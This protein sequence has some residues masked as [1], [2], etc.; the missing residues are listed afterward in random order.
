MNQH[1]RLP[2]DS[3]LLEAIRARAKQDRVSP[4]SWLKHQLGS[5]GQGT[6]SP[7]DGPSDAPMEEVMLD[8]AW[9]HF[10]ALNL[11]LDEARK[12]AN[13]IFIA[14]ETGEAHTA[15]PVS[16][17]RRHYVFHRRTTAVAI[18]IGEGQIH[19]PIDA[20]M[21]LA[22]ALYYSPADLKTAARLAA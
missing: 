8:L 9:V 7:Q 5:P 17:L 13:A 11:D 19:L 3:V 1:N 15:G 20:A 16:A 6:L 12:L 18:R 10:R 22:T 14:I 21:R 2:I 4:E